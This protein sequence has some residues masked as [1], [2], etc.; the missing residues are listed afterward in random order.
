[1]KTILLGIIY[2]IIG[3]ICQETEGTYEPAIYGILVYLA[4]KEINR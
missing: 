1:M 4:C 3:A 2:I